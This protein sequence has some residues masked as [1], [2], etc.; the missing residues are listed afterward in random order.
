MRL[1]LLT[2][3]LLIVVGGCAGPATQ[4]DLYIAQALVEIQDAMNEFRQ[5]SYDLQDRV[6]SL[7]TV[8]ARRDTVIRQ[9]AN[10]AGVPV[11]P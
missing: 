7:V 11:P 2:T 6:D 5:A 10:L 1:R 4:Q 8:V 9:L 3:G